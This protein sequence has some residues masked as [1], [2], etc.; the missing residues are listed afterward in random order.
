MMIELQSTPTFPN[1]EEKPA[2]EILIKRRRKKKREE[3]S[4]IMVA[5]WS[6]VWSAAK[7]EKS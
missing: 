3:N 5:E 2:K 7:K 1:H 4:G 6:T